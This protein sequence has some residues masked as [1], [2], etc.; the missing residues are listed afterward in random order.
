MGLRDQMTGLRDKMPSHFQVTFGLQDQTTGLRDEM[1]RDF[2]VPFRLEDE[3]PGELRAPIGLPRQKIDS[4]RGSVGSRRP[5]DGSI[6]AALGSKRGSLWQQEAGTPVSETLGSV[7]I[8]KRW[9]SETKRK[10]TS[11]GRMGRTKPKVGSGQPIR[12]ANLG[13]KAKARHPFFPI[14]FHPIHPFYPPSTS[15]KRPQMFRIGRMKS[16]GRGLSVAS[17]TSVAPLYGP[18]CP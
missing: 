14:R 8:T 2:R 7:S 15:K 13:F 5:D 12:L 18:P 3:M 11:M 4:S 16:D 9:V 17:V 6:S 1:P 10:S